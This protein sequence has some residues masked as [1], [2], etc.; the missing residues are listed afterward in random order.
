MIARIVLRTL[1]TQGWLG[2]AL[3]LVA[4]ALAAGIQ[5]VFRDFFVAVPFLLFFPATILASFF[6]GWRAGLACTGLAL[7]LARAFF[8]TEQPGLVLGG[9][10]IVRL[11]IF[12]L[13]CLLIVSLI[14]TL[15]AVS[16]QL[17]AERDRGRV[18][19]Q[20]ADHRVAN[21]LQLVGATLRLQAAGAATTELREGLAA[22][23]SRVTAIGRVHRR[24]H[25]DD[26]AHDMPFAS[27]LSDMCGDLAAQAGQ[28][29]KCSVS[30]DE[31]RIPVE[32][33]LKLGLIVNELVTNAF[34][35]TGADLEVNVKCK[36][37]GRAFTLTVVDHGRG[38]P[39]AFDPK[40]SKG[41]GMRLVSA[42]LEDL[43]GT[44]AFDRREG[45]ASVAITVPL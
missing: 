30:C 22:A 37:Q 13:V 31:F 34:K 28:N 40:T 44:I 18:L 11:A 33:A 24:L 9:P 23:L 16:M 6:G 14:A 43:D 1:R 41:L 20:E 25:R 32:K 3:G 27:Y 17:A 26:A 5:Y 35:H 45:H 12:L 4:A 21:S 7:V 29:A 39:D 8:I 10:E 2:F 38:F 15:Q 36:H 42:M 19:A